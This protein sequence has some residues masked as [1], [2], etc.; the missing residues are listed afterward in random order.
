MTITVKVLARS[1]HPGCP[2]L[3]TVQARYPRFIHAEV[4]THRAF[5]RNAS[6]SRAIPVSRM[7][8]DVIEDPAMPAEWG[9]NRPGMQ[10]GEDPGTPVPNW[11]LCSDLAPKA[12]PREVA[13]LKARDAAVA[14]ARAFADAGYHKQVVNRLLEPF[15]HISVIITATDWAN[16]FELRDSPA[17]DPTMR[18]LAKAIR[19]AIEESRP[20]EMTADDWHLPYAAHGAPLHV[21]VARCARVSYNNHDGTPSDPEADRALA[22]R[23]LA[24][25]HMSPFEH[26]ARPAPGERHGPLTGWINLRTMIERGDDVVF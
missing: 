25:R 10:A 1:R 8:R 3:I 13:W 12:L 6:S 26:Q 5:C 11:D 17:A 4:L 22:Q 20:V 24:E 9:A 7:I 15:A 18:A 16:F 21:S 14:A 19:Q 23:L 2:D